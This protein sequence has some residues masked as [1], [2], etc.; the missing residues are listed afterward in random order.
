MLNYEDIDCSQIYDEFLELISFDYPLDF[1]ITK[2]T[3]KNLFFIGMISLMG[4]DINIYNDTESGVYQN[5]VDYS[6]KVLEENFL[7]K[8]DINNMFVILPED[9]VDKEFREDGY[10]VFLSKRNTDLDIEKFD[11]KT[12]IDNAIIN[13]IK[14]NTIAIEYEKDSLTSFLELGITYTQQAIFPERRFK[15]L[16]EDIKLD[17]NSFGDQVIMQLKEMGKEYNKEY[18]KEPK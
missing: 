16:N 8:N 6:K 3:K 13:I 10:K 14:S 15:L 1:Y 11:Y 17:S 2:D 9:S 5:I 18:K 7:T 12:C 4:R